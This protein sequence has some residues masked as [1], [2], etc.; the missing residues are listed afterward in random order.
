MEQVYLNGRF[1]PLSEAQVPVMD[2]GFLF[3]DGVYEVIPAY[4]GRPLRLPHHL[5]RLDDSLAGIR[6][7]NPLTAAAWERILAVLIEPFPKIQ[8]VS[9]YIQITRGV[10]P[11]RDHA[12][13]VGVNPTVFA[14]ASPITP[15]PAVWLEEGVAAVVLEDLRWQLCHLKTITLLAN[16]LLRQTAVEAG[17]VEAILVRDGRV[18]E[19]AA[20][21]LFVC[22]EGRLLTPPKGPALLP[23][24]TRDL[25]L[26]LAER[27]GIAWGEE[28]LPLATLQ[29]ASEIWL[30]SSTREILPVTRLDGRPVGEGKPGPI[31]RRLWALY[32][33]YKDHLRRGE[34]DEP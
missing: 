10:A 31:W 8:D 29:D 1:L 3:G 11:K 5:A 28:I 21:N 23:G 7:A 32:Q 14:M 15:P 12:F 9:V 13:P 19:G 22:R 24:I 18:T 4:G 30:T 2:R 6:L 17:A 25:V 34:P 26:E 16:V 20:S 27:H 33:D